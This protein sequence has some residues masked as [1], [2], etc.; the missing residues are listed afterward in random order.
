LSRWPFRRLPHDEPAAL[1]AKLR[2]AGV[3]Q[4][5]AAS[6]DSLFH[7]DLGAVN[8]RLAELCRTNGDG[9][10]L[11]FGAVNPTLP[12]WEEDLR[13]CAEEYRMPGI[14]LHPNYHVYTLDDPRFRKLLSL[15][16]QRGLLV[17]IAL[18]MEDER[19][20]HARVVVSP[21]DPAPLAESA[22]GIKNL[23]LILLNRS[24]S[25]DW[26]L[27]SKLRDASEVYFD[28]SMLEGLGTLQDLVREA[29]L[30]RVLFGSHFPFFYLESALLKVR[31][32]ALPPQQEQAVL[33]ENARGL[34][35]RQGASQ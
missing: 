26:S 14:R 9:L 13:R 4:A 8:T 33:A 6:L 29:S 10:L 2:R 24:W 15:A 31:E 25:Q 12:D 20:Q 27:L 34:A 21:V 28:F 7:K 5:W 35:A 17:Q 16:A 19:T 22:A 1:A 30:A 3:E 32:A 23:R 11:P 18:S